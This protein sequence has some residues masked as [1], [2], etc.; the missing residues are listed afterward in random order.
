MDKQIAEAKILDA[1]GT[2]LI[3]G[4]VLPVFINELGDTFLVEEY[5]AG[6]PC[7]H[8]IKDLHDDGVQVSIDLIGYS[9][10]VNNGQ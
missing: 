7:Q 10:V 4:S 5:E 8:T 1:N 2:Y 9:K 6:C 3:D